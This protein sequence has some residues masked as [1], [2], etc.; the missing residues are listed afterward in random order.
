MAI[1]KEGFTLK[2][3]IS[4]EEAIAG[5]EK[6]VKYDD[7]EVEYRSLEEM[8]QLRNIMRKELCLNK[9]SA[10]KGLFGGR[11]IV[12]KSSKGLC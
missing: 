8:I 6:R 12:A 10:N 9:S 1:E 7:K 11:R 3:L 2:H 5:G 4:L